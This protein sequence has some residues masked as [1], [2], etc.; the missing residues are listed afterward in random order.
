MVNQWTGE[1]KEEKDYAMYPKGKWCMYDHLADLIRKDKYEIKTT[2]ENLITIIL[3][4]AENAVDEGTDIIMDDPNDI[5][6]WVREQ[7]GYSEFDY[8]V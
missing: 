2:M 4:N 1:W 7:G 3:L 8:E 6:W 5:I